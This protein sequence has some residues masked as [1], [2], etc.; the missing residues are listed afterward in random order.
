MKLKIV[1]NP[2]IKRYIKR[3]LGIEKSTYKETLGGLWEGIKW[4]CRYE[5]DTLPI[6]LI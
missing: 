3:K 1:V 2:F 6:I 5:R 4:T